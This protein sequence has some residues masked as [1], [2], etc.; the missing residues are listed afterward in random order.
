MQL[1]VS[2][3]SAAE[4]LAALAGEADLVDAKDPLAGA[5]GAVSEQ[6]L[7][8]IH[9]AVARMRPVTAALGDATTEPAIERLSR[10]FVAAGARFVKVGFAGINSG[11]RVVALIEAAVCGAKSVASEAGVIAVAYADGE[12]SAS[13][14]PAAL[15]QLSMQAGAAGILLDTANKDGPGLRG[16]MSERVLADW[17]SEAHRAGLLA[18]LAGRLTVEDLAFVQ[19]AGAD[20]AGVRGAACDG[21]RTGRVVAEKVSLLRATIERST[22]AAQRGGP[23]VDRLER[24][25]G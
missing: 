9:E 7:C 20:I 18:A 8:E 23:R 1:L 2:V 13:V 6:V 24:S 21:G 17:V 12:P 22:L 16:L 14:R 3:T 15:I 19:D 25:Q 4:A 5:L 10:R 11:P